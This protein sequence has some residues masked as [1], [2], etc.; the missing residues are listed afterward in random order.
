MARYPEKVDNYTVMAVMIK[1]ENL[2]QETPC[3]NCRI[4]NKQ[5]VSRRSCFFHEEWH[6]YKFTCQH[7][8]RKLKTE[9]ELKRHIVCHEDLKEVMCTSPVRDS[10]V[11]PEREDLTSSNKYSS[12]FT[13]CHVLEDKKKSHS[14]EN[15]YLCEICQRSFSQL[16]K[17]TVHKRIHTGEKPYTCKISHK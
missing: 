13:Q 7:C 10:Q 9:Q 3:F 11:K 12:N 5:F 15:C 6:S 2:S 8:D 14:N 1:E 16:S 4:C 17:L